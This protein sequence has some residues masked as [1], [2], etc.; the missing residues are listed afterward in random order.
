MQ[1]SKKRKAENGKD[2]DTNKKLKVLTSIIRGYC[3]RLVVALGSIRIFTE[4]ALRGQSNGVYPRR[5]RRML[6]M[7]PHRT[8]SLATPESG[9]PARCTGKGNA[10]GNYGIFSTR[11]NCSIVFY[12]AFFIMTMTTTEAILPALVCRKALS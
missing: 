10:Q 8:L 2:N 3:P 1:D 11:Y 9:P 12:V 7:R 4:A 6:P 5:A